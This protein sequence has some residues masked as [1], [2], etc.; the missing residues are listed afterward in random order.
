VTTKASATMRA[1][2]VTPGKADSLHLREVRRPV[3]GDVPDGR[4]VVVDVIRVG[5]CGT[6]REIVDALFGTAPAGDDFLVIGHENLGRVAAV[7]PNV[8]GGLT[9]GSLVVATVRRPGTSIY[10]SIGL[11]DMTTDEARERGINRLHGF[12][13]E[14]YVDDAA[15]LV[16]LPDSLEPVG[17]LLEPL[18]ISEKGIR[19]AMEIQ[20]RMRVWRPARTAVLGAGPVGLLTALA[21]RLRGMDVTVYSRRPAPYR[22]SDLLG[23]IGARYLSSSDTT[24][25]ALSD[26][27]GPLDLIVDASGFSPLALGAARVLGKNGV[28]ILASVTGGKVTA[29][30]PTDVINEGFVLNNKVMVGTVN[31]HRDDFVTG[32]EDLL[33]AEAFYPGWL[34]QLITTRVNGLEAHAELLQHLH[35][36]RDAIK[37]VVEVGGR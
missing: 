9:P 20:R 1:V 10:D 28:L 30:L 34:G 26:A 31:A 14:A 22:N 33:R 15:F 18:S 16:P 2:A 11:Q 12:L 29:E 5:A 21:L 36:D 25:D 37:V 23:A 7:G 19:Q 17:V 13:A 6:D 35:D 3:V 27:A 24:L 4:G 32:V 8:P